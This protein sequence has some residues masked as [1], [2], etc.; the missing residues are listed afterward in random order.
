MVSGICFRDLD[1]DPVLKEAFYP[2]VGWGLQ[3]SCHSIVLWQVSL[4]SPAAE[5]SVLRGK[6]SC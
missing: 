2:C 4:E 6:S 5:M 3:R 1:H